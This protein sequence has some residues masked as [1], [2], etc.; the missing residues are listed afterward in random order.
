MT[1]IDKQAKA[2][3]I[4]FEVIGDVDKHRKRIRVNGEEYIMSTHWTNYGMLNTG[5]SIFRLLSSIA[6]AKKR[7]C[8]EEAQ[9]LCQP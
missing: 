6:N 3:G 1:A 8:K 4:P 5:T 9:K 7:K 2:A